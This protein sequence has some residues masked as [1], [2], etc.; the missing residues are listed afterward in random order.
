MRH[1]VVRRERGMALLIALVVLIVVSILGATAM[2][3]ALFQSKISVNAQASQMMFQGAESGIESVL[4]LAID[5]IDGG[6]ATTAPGHVFYL[7]A[8]LGQ[9]Q[10][11]CIL[12]NGALT[13]DSNVTF[14]ADGDDWA[15]DYTD[16]A[17][18][19]DSPVMITTVVGPTPPSIPGTLTPEGSTLCGNNASTICLHQI[20]SQAFSSIVGLDDN[21]QSH[22]QIWS[23]TGAG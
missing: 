17:Q 15:V 20:Y 23:L 6:I 13:M 2:R 4:Q 12:T 5:Q 8:S 22:V 9:A 16:C 19:T 10:R 7:A 21:P 1:P 3:S 11:V 14:T 18:R